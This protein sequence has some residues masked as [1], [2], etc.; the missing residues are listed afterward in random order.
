V[1][2]DRPFT[3][4]GFDSL[5]AVEFRNRLKA[6]T[7]LK[8]SATMVFDH[9]TAAALTDH[10]LAG[11]APAEVD[12]AAGLLAELDRLERSFAQ[13][14][15]AGLEDAVKARITD[16]LHAV[17]SNWRGRSDVDAEPDGPDVGLVLKTASADE[18]LRFIDDELGAA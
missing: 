11:L 3:E 16:R 1:D 4:L 13:A 8:L 18:L 15:A 12:P 14:G 9:P 17:M 10:L 7:G 5:T 6:A 2:P